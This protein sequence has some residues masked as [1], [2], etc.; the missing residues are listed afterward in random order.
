[1]CVSAVS[2]KQTSVEQTASPVGSATGKSKASVSYITQG[3][4]N[5]NRKRSDND[6]SKLIKLIDTS[7]KAL[8][9]PKV[10]KTDAPVKVKSP[11]KSPEPERKV[12]AV[13]DVA[14]TSSTQP[15]QV[16]SSSDDCE[17]I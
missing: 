1:M 5:G 12:S 9:T 7:Y 14:G 3:L 16:T 13:S 8:R 6:F 11:R 2:T 15:V 17:T 10:D 4:E